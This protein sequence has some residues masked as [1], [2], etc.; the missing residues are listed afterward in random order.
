MGANEGMLFVFSTSERWRI[1]M[2]DMLFG[3]D[4]LWLGEDGT[5]LDM[6]EY[7]YPESYPFVFE[8][9]EPARYILE[10]NA[11]FAGANGI[12]VGDTLEMGL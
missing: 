8:P 6:Y 1:W 12:R 9:G 4:I 3:I 11:G 2:R 10:V 7:V 5:V